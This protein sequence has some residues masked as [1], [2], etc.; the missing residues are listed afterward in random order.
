MT[1]EQAADQAKAIRWLVIGGL[2]AEYGSRLLP[3]TRGELKMRANGVINAANKLQSY[4]IHHPNASPSASQVF[5]K[6]FS[7][8]EIVLMGELLESVWGISEDDLENIITTLK[9]NIVEQ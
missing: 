5:K 2:L 7:K 8:N 1:P 6:E 9:E 3:D 4:F